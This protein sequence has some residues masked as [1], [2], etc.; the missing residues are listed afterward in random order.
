MRPSTSCLIT[1]TELQNHLSSPHNFN[2]V[3]CE[4]RD[5]NK[6]D[7]DFLNS[8]NHG[9]GSVTKPKFENIS[10]FENSVN[11]LEDHSWERFLR[12][13]SRNFNS[14]IG[15]NVTGVTDTN[16]IQPGGVHIII[17]KYSS[18]FSFKVEFLEEKIGYQILKI[19]PP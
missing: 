3:K 11:V 10:D 1:Q 5:L 8:V 18:N 15:K 4:T 13:K 6:I 17:G 12:N 16:F 19:L 2:T 14:I 7:V 9:R